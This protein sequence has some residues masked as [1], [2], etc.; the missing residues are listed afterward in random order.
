MKKPMTHL[1]KCSIFA[2]LLQS[3]SSK[4]VHLKAK[5]FGQ[6]GKIKNNQQ[7]VSVPTELR[8]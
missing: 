4:T 3:L 8:K 2:L 6:S 5:L 1:W 7:K